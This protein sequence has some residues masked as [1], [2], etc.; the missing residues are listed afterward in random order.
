MEEKTLSTFHYGQESKTGEECSMEINGLE[1]IFFQSIKT[2]KIFINTRD[3]QLK[4]T[5]IENI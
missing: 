1:S 2:F 3:P 4:I 5:S